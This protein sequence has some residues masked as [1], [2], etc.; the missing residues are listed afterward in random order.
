MIVNG[1]K[2]P[3]QNEKE[4]LS[5]VDINLTNKFS[6]KKGKIK[7][8]NDNEFVEADKTNKIGVKGYYYE[9]KTKIKEID[10]GLFYE[11]KNFYFDIKK[12]KLWQNEKERNGKYLTFHYKKNKFEIGAEVG[13][14]ESYSYLYPYLEY[15]GDWN[16]LY[17]QSI[18]GKDM[19]TFCAV[20]NHLLTHH[21]IASK[22]KGFNTKYNKELTNKWYSFEVSKIDNNIALTPQFSYKFNKKDE[23]KNFEFYYYLSG[24]YQMNSSTNDCYYSPNFYDSTYLEI[25]PV[26]KKLELIGKIGYSFYTDTLLYSYGFNFTN[27][28]ISFDCMKNH[29]YKSGINGYWYEECNLKAGVK[30]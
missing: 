1:V 25:H 24:W 15:K 30:W 16:L 3:L 6:I 11:N 13:N 26:Y 9:D 27:D 19:K 10:Y 2:R 17:Y 28:Y 18:T 20:D 14:Y 22:Y 7:Y 21:L 23:Y 8:S 4:V 12:W 5:L 29:S